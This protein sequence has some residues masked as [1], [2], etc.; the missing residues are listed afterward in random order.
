MPVPETTS[1]ENLVRYVGGK[2]LATGRG[3]AWREIKAS[4]IALPPVVDALHMP[5]VS[6]PVLVWITS[7]EVE[8][9]ERENGGPWLTNRVK[10]GAFF[11]T[12]GDG[13]RLS[14]VLDTVGGTPVGEV[15]QVAQSWRLDCRLRPS[16]WAVPDPSRPETFS[17]VVLAFTDSGSSVGY[18]TRR[19]EIQEIYQKLG[20]LIADGSLSV[21]VEHVYP[22]EQF[23]ETFK[24]SLKSN[25]SGKILFKF[26][27][28]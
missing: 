6:E 25:R 7:G 2:C 5:S 22:L 24:Q 1:A 23:K 3:E 21:A 13:K 16:K 12:T 10:K 15:G 18:A 9:Q 8:V 28:H 26:G 27:A 17:S 19:S 14:L 11:L 20:D 4:V